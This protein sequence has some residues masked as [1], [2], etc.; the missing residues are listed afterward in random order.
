MKP[1]TTLALGQA[2]RRLGLIVEAASVVGV[3]AVRRGDVDFWQKANLDPG[4]VL[5]SAFVLGLVLW[6]AGTE[7]IRRARRRAD[8][9]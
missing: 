3:L 2:L 7:T 1:A 5:P 6:A 8:G 9:F 4:V